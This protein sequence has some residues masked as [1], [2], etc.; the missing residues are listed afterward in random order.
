MDKFRR[1]AV[2]TPYLLALFVG[3]VACDTGRAPPP[4]NR[5]EKI[6]REEKELLEKMKAKEKAKADLMA[7][8]SRFID[9]GGWDSYDKGI[10]N[11]YTRATAIE[12]TNRSDF[13]VADI[14]GKITYITAKGKELAT[15]P[16][17]A[18]GEVRAQG[19]AKLRVD[20]GEISGKASK[21]RVEVERVRI[22][23]G[24]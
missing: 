10:I 17:T 4:D 23:G 3:I 24:V 12:F 7:T 22:I 2:A 16:F 6:T 8:P 15:V 21:A 9:G 11:D 1:S 18:T 14:Q 19:Q 5:T 13:D 20:A